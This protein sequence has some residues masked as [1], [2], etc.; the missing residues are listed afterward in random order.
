M[1]DRNYPTAG[2]ADPL[3]Q[4]AQT[5]AW[6]YER[7]PASIKP[8]YGVTHLE[9]ELLHRPTYV[10][11]QLPTYTTTHHPTS[12]SGVFDSAVNTTET[13]VMNLLSAIE[14]RAVHQ[15]GPAAASLLPP[16]RTPMWQTGANS[17]TELFLTGALPST[18]TFSS[19][20]ALSS[21]QHTGAFSSRSY[22]ATSLGLH[23]P[24]FS[25][26]T[27]GLLSPHHD[28]LLQLK[29]GQTTLP[30]SL[31]FDR[32]PTAT[33]PP[34][35]STYRSAQESAPH[36]LQPQFGLLPFASQ[37]PH[38]TYEVP[39]FSG[40]IERTLQRECSVIKHHQRPSSGSH[41]ASE[42]VPASQHP[43][44][45]YLGSGNE[46][47]DMP[48]SPS[49]GSDSSHGINGAAPTKTGVASQAY[50]SIL[51]SPSGY[52]SSAAKTKDCTSNLNPGSQE[53]HPHSQE[54]RE[55]YPSPGQKQGSVIASQQT[56]PYTSAQLPSL[57]ST[58]S[59]S[60]SYVNS[61]AYSSSSVSSSDKLPSL[62]KSLPSLSGHSGNVVY[63]S[64]PGHGLGNEGQY[65]AQVQR[66]CPG[67][68][69]P[70]Y[71]SSHSQGAPNVSYAS[72]L[73]GQASVSQSQSYATGQSLSSS[74][75]P[76][77]G[78]SLSTPNSSQGY[79]P[80]SSASHAQALENNC[81]S[82][83][84]DLKPAYGKMK[85][86]REIPLQDLQALQQNSL[87]T[88][89]PRGSTDP[90]VQNNDNVVYVVSKMDDRYNTQSVIRSNS[91]SEDQLM[92]SKTL[93]NAQIMSSHA[94]NAEEIKQHS[95]LLKGPEPPQENHQAH[96]HSAQ[97]HTQNQYIRVPNTL[98]EPNRDLQ[99]I[100]LQHPL[101]YSGH[102]SSKMQ[103][104]P[105]GPSQGL[106]QYLQMEGD[107]LASVNG[108]Q[109]QQGP[110][111]QNPI[112]DSSKQ[113]LST[114]KD[115][116]SQSNCQQQDAKHHF[117]L[118]SICFPE[119]MLMADD[120]NILSNVDDI[121]AA[122]A[123][124]CGVTPQDYAKA[125]SG[126]SEGD[127]SDAKGHFQPVDTRHQSHGF[128]ATSAQQSI[129]SNTN[130]HNTM[131]LTLNG[132]SMTSD[133]TTFSKGE[134]HLGQEYPMS[135]SHTTIVNSTHDVGAKGLLQTSGDEPNHILPKGH[136]VYPADGNTNGGHSENDYHLSG[137]GYDPLGHIGKVQAKNQM[138]K[139]IKREDSLVE[140]LSDS[141]SN[142][143]KRVRSK[144]SARSS[145]PE[146]E[147]GQTRKKTVQTKR[148]T[149]RGSDPTSSP[150]TSEVVYDG[151]Q[152]Q[153]RMRQKIREVEEQQPEVKTGFIGSFLDFLKSGPKQQF[154]S[155]PVR[156]P[157][158]TR[159]PSASSK[160]LPCPIPPLH[161]TIPSPSAPLI[162]Q[163]THGIG[164]GGSSQ[165]LQ[166]RLDEE[167]QRNLE[168]LPSFSSDE[169]ESSTRKNQALQNSISSALSALDEPSDRRHKS[170]NHLSG[171]LLKPEPAPSMPHSISMAHEQQQTTSPKESSA[172]GLLSSA[173]GCPGPEG[174]KPA[175]PGQ[176][177]FQ[178][179]S[180]AIEGLTDEELSDSGG[181]GMYRERDEFV[182][183]NEDIES[184]KVTLTVG[185][186]PPAIWKVQ[187]AL[188][189][190][191]VPEL[192]DG[193]R[194][195]SATNS[196][197]GYFG[198]AKTMYR[199]VYVKFLD[200]VNKREYVRVC[201]LK[202]RCKPMHSIRGSQ[203]KTLLGLKTS[204]PSDILAT[205]TSLKLQSKSRLKQPKIKAEPPPKK[206][207]KWK[208]EYSPSPSE[209]SSE[210]GG[211]NDEFPP[212][213]PFAS[214]F[215]NT[216][217]MKETF[218]SFVELLIS[219][220][221]DA[222]VISTLERETDEQLLPHMKRVEE[223]I[224]D[225]RRH[226]LPRL[227]VG[228]LF[229]TSLD[230]FPEISVVTE[231]KKDG[232]TPAFKVRLSGK[233]YNRKNMK[234]SK[235]PSQ[236]PLE[237][238][239]DQQKT[240]WFSL[241]HS[242]RHYKYHTYLMCKDEIASL[243]LQTGDMGQEETVQL[244]MRNGA[245][246]ESLFDRFGELLNQVQ[247]ACL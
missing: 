191:F 180:V 131:A 107:H 9:S 53:G 1:M 86:E 190:K 8:S 70:T 125:A 166:K 44:Q 197:L 16:F 34:Q 24:T 74:Y 205:P 110:V 168:T 143:K 145:S 128:S 233:A 177:A 209:S 83:I 247:Q 13:S 200:T 115:P 58:L 36:L 59:H 38:Q 121:L 215:L 75:P 15:A 167:F 55:S 140:C 94:M 196:Y 157:S 165:Q 179:S 173:T 154:S 163:E 148:Q 150:S 46:D 129:I 146:G 137:S 120:R 155:P 237:Y 77:R 69:S 111:G 65:G 244:C 20:A 118:S 236:L 32:L 162:T 164:I 240:Q 87:E 103:Q 112:T 234:P 42:Q 245:W 222:D 31:A 169:D 212:L 127:M 27:N 116:Y 136:S 78:Q 132:T 43:M 3:A 26:T 224:S 93:S 194:V 52:T 238:A 206:R 14:S 29:P 92:G 160:H 82:S 151:Y 175:H 123:A 220:A 106:V 5:V 61:Q 246:V 133:G 76:T 199:R 54:S 35:S 158:R 84:Q 176:L 99:M 183:K 182:V 90:A 40:S 30:T 73:H 242:L 225:N 56:Q 25:T 96:V 216:R 85:L 19:T 22:N 101:I 213:V 10:S 230:S 208:E 100:L 184:L 18:A 104:I 64:S 171:S 7:S 11:T 6:A 89:S 79:T 130:A 97:N 124:A 113:H 142:P 68:L 2:F 21:Y 229:K 49:T 223:M 48:C 114:P 81:R 207:R 91:R 47:G 232:E 221:L 50:S 28:P 214:R 219:V 218:R 108:S 71:P 105:T 126:T 181:E 45:A 156:T 211:E 153:E 201:N 170:D 195:F 239:V 41:T 37:Q 203:A 189:Q 144:A 62:Y 109:S 33:L 228:Q 226:L 241:Y 117:A 98:L 119:S 185:H 204:P 152:Q 39:V 141:F 51:P 178:L 88:S 235:S 193:R 122:T 134:G 139:G 17:A 172:P 60:Q 4:P 231:L 138:H 135:H 227:R 57:L 187:K 95:L 192:R 161:P 23:E 102:N 63:S 72:Q 174:L 243:R 202:P 186:E 149:S 210:E 80:F 188:L 12:L 198:D 66:Q 217:T 147:N 159:K 67:N